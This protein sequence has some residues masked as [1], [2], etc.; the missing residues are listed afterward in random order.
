MADCNDH[1]EQLL[2]LDQRDDAIVPDTVGP[3]LALVA[4]Q[5]FPELSWITAGDDAL[6]QIVDQSPLNRSVELAQLVAG[7]RT[8][9]NRPARVPS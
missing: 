5:Q 7:I 4:A 9:L 1:H 2:I 3:E 8:E 6:L